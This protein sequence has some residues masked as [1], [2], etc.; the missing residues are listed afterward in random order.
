MKCRKAMS[1]LVVLC[2]WLGVLGEIGFPVS[3]LEFR[4]SGG[5][6]PLIGG[7]SGGDPSGDGATQ[8]TVHLG[9]EILEEGEMRT[10]ETLS[11]EFA[12]NPYLQEGMY[13]GTLDVYLDGP[14]VVEKGAFLKIGTFAIGSDGEASPALHA[15]LSDEPLIVVRE[16]GTLVLTDVELDLQGEGLLILQDPGAS[17]KVQE[18]ELPEDL[19]RRSTPFVENENRPLKDVWLEE[20]TPLT[21]ED[22]PSSLMAYVQENGKEEWRE[23]ALAWD[24]SGYDGRTSGE[25]TLTGSFVDAGGT[26]IPSEVPPSVSVRWYRLDELVVKD[27]F[28]SGKEAAAAQLVLGQLPDELDRLWGEVSEDEGK[29]WTVW[30]EPLF[31]LSQDVHGNPVAIFEV[32][33]DTP[34]RYRVRGT[35]AAEDRFWLT[36]SFLLPEEEA[37]DQGGNRGGAVNPLPPDREP[38]PIDDGA[39]EEGDPAEENGDPTE[40]TPAEPETG[41]TEEPVQPETEQLEPEQPETAEKPVAAKPWQEPER[42]TFPAEEPMAITETVEEAAVS[43]EEEILEEPLLLTE[44][45]EPDPVETENETAEQEVSVLETDAHSDSQTPGTLSA[46]QQALLVLGGLAVSGGAAALVLKRSRKA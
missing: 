33:D 12:G 11:P 2:L 23:V 39:L 9:P 29:T 41:E 10:Y 19:V 18:M 22:L 20:G 7:P 25:W 6:P 24:L 15:E 40:E 8:H 13:P 17:V 44:E 14:V 36:E 21:I 45:P 34:R 37:A 3:A 5:D 46:S 31:I 30:E 4:D 43:P 28:W 16:G 1:I 42:E 38:L 35:N 27:S 26:P 32:Q